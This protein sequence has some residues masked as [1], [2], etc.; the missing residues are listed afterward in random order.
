MRRVLIAP[1]GKPWK[2]IRES[3]Y[4]WEEVE[5]IFNDDRCRSRSTLPLLRKALNPDCTVVIVLDT[6]LG[7]VPNNY[8]ELTKEIGD[9]YKDFINNQL[10]LRDDVKIIV[11]PGVGRFKTD[12]GYVEFKGSLIDF[13]YIILHELSRILVELDDKAEVYIDISHGLNFMPTLTYRAVNEVLGVL[14][15]TKKISLEV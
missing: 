3:S 6:A 14:A 2:T 5:Y 11:A 7:L 10:G 1:W 12:D 13:Y 9:A 15:H 8:D 4:S